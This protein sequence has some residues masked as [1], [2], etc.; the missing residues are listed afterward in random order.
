MNRNVKETLEA[1]NVHH[2]KTHLYHIASNSKIERFHRVLHD[3][4]AKKLKDNVNI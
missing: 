1:L 3:V 2:I 4:L